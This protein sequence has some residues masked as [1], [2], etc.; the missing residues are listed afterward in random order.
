MYHEVGA[1]CISRSSCGRVPIVCRKNISTCLPN[2]L[3]YDVS[4]PMDFLGGRLSINTTVAAIFTQRGLG[5]AAPFSM[6]RATSMV[7]RPCR[8]LRPL[9]S[10][11]LGE[12]NC[13]MI[14]V[15]LQRLR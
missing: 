11:V 8:S 7:V 9:C 10:G 14:A 2:I 1:R 13:W 15:V 6:H 3:W 4:P 12:L 5:S